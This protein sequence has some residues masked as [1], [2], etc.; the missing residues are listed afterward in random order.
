MQAARDPRAARGVDRTSEV[1]ALSNR[2]IAFVTLM[3]TYAHPC[4]G[5]FFGIADAHCRQRG[6]APAARPRQ[7]KTGF[8][9]HAVRI[10]RALHTI[11]GRTT[12]LTKIAG[13]S[14]LFDDPGHMSK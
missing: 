8:G 1:C 13:K 5:Q 6:R 11:E 3:R 4:A 12:R 14:T 10:G 2:Q 7:P 9:E